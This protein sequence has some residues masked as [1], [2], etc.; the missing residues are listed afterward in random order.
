ML[1]STSINDDWEGSSFL[2]VVSKGRSRMWRT[3]GLGTTASAVGTAGAGVG[4]VGA[5]DFVVVD[6]VAG[7]EDFPLI[8]SLTFFHS[9][10]R[11]FFSFFAAGSDGG[12]M[13][14]ECVGDG[15]GGGCHQVYKRPK[16]GGGSREIKLI[17][18][19]V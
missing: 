5:E 8:L 10:L 17:D 11:P 1:S 16:Q 3:C 7:F 12:F 19:V 18:Q 2:V 15:S 9:F 14:K 6:V 13:T 4:S